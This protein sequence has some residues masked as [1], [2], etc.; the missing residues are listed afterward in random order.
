MVGCYEALVAN[1]GHIVAILR[2]GKLA[3][4]CGNRWLQLRVSMA[5]RHS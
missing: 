3:M 2:V 5:R 1:V 4:K